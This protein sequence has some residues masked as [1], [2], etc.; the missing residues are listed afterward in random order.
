LNRNR[1][2]EKA[3]TTFLLLVIAQTA[4]SIEEYVFRLY[5]VFAPARFVSGLISTDPRTGFVLFNVA[6]ITFGL[7]CY[8]VPVRRA[9]SAAIPLMWFWIVLEILNGMGHS[10]ISIMERS[11]IPGT[12]MAPFLLIIALYLLIQI[13]KSPVG[14]FD[15]RVR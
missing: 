5:D 4:H 9:W 13:V 14:C 1:I 3:S 2:N 10:F 7:W 12:A 11:Y 6:L 8:A 15:Y